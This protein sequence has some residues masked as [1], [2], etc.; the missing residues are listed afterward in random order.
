MTPNHKFLARNRLTAATL[1]A[2]L[3]PAL[4]YGQD[5]GTNDSEGSKATTLDK[6]TVTGS[7]IPQT[8]IETATPVITIDAEQIH[9]RGYTSV[10]D[11][12]RSSSFASGG[13]QGGETSASFTQGAET[14]SMFGL[15]PSYTKYLINGRPM[16]NYPALYNGTDA[17]SR[18]IQL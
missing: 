8:Q 5:A 9:A 12:L 15:S 1:A 16:G 14:V 6:V 2:L 10:L 3:L 13:V 11:I 17:F 18:W 7:L 4:A